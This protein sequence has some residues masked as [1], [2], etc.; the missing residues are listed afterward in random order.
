MNGVIINGN[1]DVVSHYRNHVIGGDAAFVMNIADPA[2]AVDAMVR[3][4]LLDIASAIQ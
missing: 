3:K 2:T 4:F 1:P